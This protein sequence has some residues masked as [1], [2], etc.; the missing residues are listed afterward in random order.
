MS[1]SNRVRLTRLRKQLVGL[2]R[3]FRRVCGFYAGE[4]RLG[5]AMGR[6]G[7]ET[8]WL[9]RGLMLDRGSWR[10]RSG[11]A[12]S[13]GQRGSRRV[14]SVDA[15]H[16]AEFGELLRNHGALARVGMK[17]SEVTRRSGPRPQ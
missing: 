10:E 15:S 11:Y 4:G 13:M 1:L 12:L 3:G 14:A 5:T 8:G 7:V 6:P 16:A 9:R 17:W 2:N